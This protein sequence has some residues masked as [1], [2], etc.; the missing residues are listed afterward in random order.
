MTLLSHRSLARL[1]AAYYVT[2]G[3]WPIAHL[4]S[5]E[6]VTG[7]KVDHWLV[8]TFGALVTAAGA[9]LAAGSREPPS[10]ALVVLGGGMALALSAA[11]VVY[12]LERRISPVYLLDAA[13]ELGVAAGWLGLMC[14]SDS[15]ESPRT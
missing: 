4:A 8:K 15:V 6:A 9:A 10:R 5:F 2:T 3:V 1:Q 13:L 11:E 7:P 12:V 14:S